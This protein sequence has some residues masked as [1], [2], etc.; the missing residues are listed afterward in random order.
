MRQRGQRKNNIK[1]FE[2]IFSVMVG[3]CGNYNGLFYSLTNVNFSATI[4]FSGQPT[5]SIFCTSSSSRFHHFVLFRLLFT[6]I[7]Q[8]ENGSTGVQILHIKWKID[9][10]VRFHRRSPA[11]THTSS[12]P[13]IN[14]NA[15]DARMQFVG[16]NER[17]REW[18]SFLLSFSVC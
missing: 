13:K 11:H 6:A 7:R 15:D 5:S 1:H 16:T 18:W 10:C 2:K 17:N 3:F 12:Q 8:T 14:G 9:A 4:S